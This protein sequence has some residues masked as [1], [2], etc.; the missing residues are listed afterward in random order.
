MS[1]CAIVGVNWGDEGKGRMVDYLAS[2][3]DVVVRYQGGSNAGHTVINEYGK[4]ALNLMP[5]GIFRP[6]VVNVLGNGTVVDIEHLC[7][8]MEKLRAAGID[9]NPS[10]LK[11]SDRC[12]IVFPF[13]KDQDGLEEARLKDAK[14]GSTKRGIAPVYSDKYQ[15]KGIQMGDLLYPDVLEKHLRLLLDWKNLT[16]TGVYGAAPYSFEDIMAWLKRFGDVLKPYITDTGLYLHQA[17]KSG[18]RILFEAQLGALR[19]IELGIYPFTSSSS[20]LAAYAPLGA[21][22]PGVRVDEVI[23]VVK[24]YSTCV[25]EGPFVAE[26]FGKDAELLREAGGEYGAATGRP[27]RVGPFDIV[28]TR[29]GVRLQGTTGIALTK[30]DV[31]SYMDQIPVCTVYK[32]GNEIVTEFPFTPLIDG[33]QPVIEY[34]PGWKKDISGAR[35]FEELPKEAQ[36]YVLYIERVL[37]CPITYVSVGADRNA[38]LFR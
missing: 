1:T 36:E 6:E 18:K 22:I 33:A 28:A 21:G 9:I 11:I 17:N 23:G 3:Y 14:Y 25:G 26:W 37:E 31:L 15:K 13:H 34:L 35:T 32:L 24:A 27:R 29:Y 7:G 20:S 19:D 10:R 4:F 5:S 38:L 12:S 8:E 30:M 16:L 2:Q